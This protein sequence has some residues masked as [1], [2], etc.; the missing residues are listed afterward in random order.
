MEYIINEIMQHDLIQ[1]TKP[2]QIDKNFQYLWFSKKNPFHVRCYK[3]INVNFIF[4][5]YYYFKCSNDNM[6]DVF[7]SIFINFSKN[8][9]ETNTNINEISN[10]YLFMEKYTNGDTSL[11]ISDDIKFMN[12]SIYPVNITNIESFKKNFPYKYYFTLIWKID[13]SNTFYIIG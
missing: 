7:I 3:Y 6:T 2:D 11:Y 9:T 1:I 5:N 4:D 10:K 12:G 13:N 8:Y